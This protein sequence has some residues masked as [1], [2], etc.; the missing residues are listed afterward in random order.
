MPTPKQPNQLLKYSNLAIQMSVIIGLAAWG[1]NKLD[2]YYKN[3]T[4]IYTIVL[5][6]LGIGAAL[7][8]VLKDLIKSQK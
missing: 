4:P 2:I 1:G 8:I 7:Y 5:S 3:E 6:L